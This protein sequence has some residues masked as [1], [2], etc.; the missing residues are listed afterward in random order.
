[1]IILQFTINAELLHQIK[2]SEQLDCTITTEFAQKSGGCD[3]VCGKF[4][5]VINLDIN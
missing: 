3:S 5:T 1:M 4:T 2:C